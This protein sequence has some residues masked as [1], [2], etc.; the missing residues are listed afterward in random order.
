MRLYQFELSSR[1]KK[2]HRKRTE[3]PEEVAQVRQLIVNL[4]DPKK[5][6]DQDEVRR[7]LNTIK[8]HIGSLTPSTSFLGPPCLRSLLIFT[9]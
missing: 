3:N 9:D 5:P 7:F 6:T 4:T 1:K 2:R 8:V